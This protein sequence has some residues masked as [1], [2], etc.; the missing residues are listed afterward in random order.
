MIKTIFLSLLFST[1]VF[2]DAGRIFHFTDDSTGD[3]VMQA[4]FPSPEV[5]EAFKEMA[6]AEADDTTH[7]PSCSATKMDNRL[8]VT[9]IVEYGNL[10]FS[11][12]YRFPALGEC[13]QFMQEFDDA[14]M[15]YDIDESTSKVSQRCE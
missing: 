1:V 7:N 11:V 12:L 4:E 15:Q 5:C 2:A 14:A 13:K 8:P 9:G 6:L 10:G 3:V